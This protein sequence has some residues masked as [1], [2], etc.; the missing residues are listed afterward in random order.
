MSANFTPEK[1]DLKILTP[2]KMQVLTNFPYI[3][4]D[5]DALT[6]YQLLCKIVEYLNNVI[7]ETNE[8]T[9]QTLSLY[10]AYVSLQ[11]YV[12]NYFDNLDVQE[13]INKK[14]DEMAEDGTLTN[15]I[16]G[17][18]DPIYQE[19]EHNINDE[20]ASFKNTVN[21]A[22]EEQ[23][24]DI[25]DFKTAINSEMTTLS[26]KVDSA[27]SGSPL[28]ASS[29]SG[30][31]DTSRVYVNTTDGKW[32]YY[33][34]DSWEIGGTYQ[35]TGIETNSV[36][37]ND[38]E[39]NKV[40]LTN[41]KART[42]L[43]NLVYYFY[44]VAQW[45][46]SQDLLFKKGTSFT[47]SPTFL[48]N[49][50]TKIVKRD[51]TG[52]NFYRDLNT[53]GSYTLTSD[54]Y[55][56]LWFTPIDEN[57]S[58]ETYTVDDTHKLTTDDITISQPYYLTTLN[59]N[60]LYKVDKDVFNSLFN[61]C[62]FDTSIHHPYGY[63][64]RG[65]IYGIPE[66][67]YAYSDI[68]L[69]VKT[70][71]RYGIIKFTAQGEKI[72]DSGWLTT[73]SKIN[74]G[75]YYSISIS[76]TTGANLTELICKEITF[77]D[78]LSLS[79]KLDDEDPATYDYAYDGNKL[80][81]KEKHGF[82]IETYMNISSPAGIY[83][84]GFAIYDNYLVQLY[85]DGLT[86]Q[87]YDLTE[88]SLLYTITCSNTY[89]HGD[90]C[91][92]S[93]TKYDESDLLPLLYVTADSTPG[94]VHVIR[95][96]NSSTASVIKSYLF[97]ITDGYYCGYTFD[98][99]NNILYSRGYKIQNYRES[100]NNAMI[101]ASYNMNNEIVENDT[102]T[103]ELIERHEEPFIYCEQGN[104]YFK[105]YNYI[106]SSYLYT[107]QTTKIYVIDPTS[108]KVVTV[109]NEFPSEVLNNEVEGVAFMLNNTKYD[110]IIGTRSKYYSISIE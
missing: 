10:N 60:V 32:Y 9:E 103:F 59:S 77:S 96:S 82:D 50:K 78:V 84:Q 109:F 66:P 18:I 80:N 21:T 7:A 27:T 107:E 38:L 54:E 5:F 104:C 58:S 52:T 44:G 37:F 29:T 64:Y 87:I 46:V 85:G 75:D 79:Y 34:G 13:E 101:C 69:S 102:Y 63:A 23:D 47:F 43:S 55:I 24:T 92:F 68:Y 51:K 108:H 88:K 31:T 67:Q 99:D 4:A 8:V 98:F 105:G 40:I 90:T 83:T 3:E 11:N 12:N 19:Y 36:E 25:S 28:V 30:M 89:N 15:L 16:K 106:P 76:K 61:S 100:T 53:T 70:G 81:L 93:N 73:D 57:W 2:F 42:D 45:K 17:Y 86:I 65:Y 14:L 6:N 91:Q 49:Y 39:E 48:A 1:E 35:S 74:K 26:N 72:S 33:D 95:I 110:M 41:Y 20:I 94:V 71:Y 56:S 97:P 22:I 62:A